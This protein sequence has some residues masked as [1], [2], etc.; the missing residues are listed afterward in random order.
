[1]IFWMEFCVPISHVSLV[2]CGALF[3]RLDL[4]HCE[5]RRMYEIQLLSYRK[6]LLDAETQANLSLIAYTS[7]APAVFR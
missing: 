5:F 3:L 4:W 7:V 6:F 2:K 1:M